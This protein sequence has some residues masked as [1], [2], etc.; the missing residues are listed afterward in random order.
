LAPQASGTPLVFID[1]NILT[2]GVDTPPLSV[3]DPASRSAWSD[4][5][6]YLHDCAGQG[7]PLY[8]DE[9]STSPWTP[10]AIPGYRHFSRCGGPAWGGCPYACPSCHYAA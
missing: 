3:W 6:C 10:W 1:A 2:R 9:V 7:P 5:A 8:W 4:T